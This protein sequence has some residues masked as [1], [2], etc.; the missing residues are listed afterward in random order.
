MEGIGV[1]LPAETVLVAGAA[2]AAAGRM[3]LGWVLVAAIA[4]GAAGGAIGYWIGLRGG[5]PFVRRFGD[6]LRLGTNALARTRA[7]FDR[8]GRAAVVAGRFVAVVRSYVGLMAGIARMSFASFM[9]Y[10]TLGAVIWTVAF[11]SLGYGFGSKLPRVERGTAAAM[12][13]VALLATLAVALAVIARAGWSAREAVWRAFEQRW[14]RVARSRPARRLAERYP[15]VLRFLA[16]RLSPGGYLGLHLTI[17]MLVSLGALWLFGGI[18]ED[19]VEGEA[20]TRFDVALAQRLHAAATPAGLVVSRLLSD[21]GSFPSMLGLTIVLT[22]GLLLARR[23]LFATVWVIALLGGGVLDFGLKEIVRRPRPVFAHPFALV[24]SWSFPSGHAMGSLI[25]F[26]MITYFLFDRVRSAAGRTA[27]VAVAT[28]LILGI[29]GSRLYLGVHYFSDVI[30]G[31]AAG[32]VWVATCISGAA[33]VRRR[34]V[35]R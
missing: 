3:A 26:S 4:G 29:G 34:R 21:I 15:G 20:L 19:V 16:R 1:P 25:A 33:M 18:L 17:G 2:F 27:I 7:F 8:Y 23:R 9:L 5:E 30:G 6:R 28:L 13:T 35:V 12:L 32:I 24:P 31:Y 14:Q 10:N 22:V 11:G